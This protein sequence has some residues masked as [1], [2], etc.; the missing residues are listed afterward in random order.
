MTDNT[1]TILLF[2]CGTAAM[3]LCQR[4][5]EDDNLISL[6][7]FMFGPLSLAFACFIR[8][9]K[10]NRSQTLDVARL[11]LTALYSIAFLQWMSRS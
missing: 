5:G 4:D 7:L 1:I 10:S 6:I 3:W 11:G 9:N 8:N 2:G